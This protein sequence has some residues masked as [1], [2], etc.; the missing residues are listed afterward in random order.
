MDRVIQELGQGFKLQ[1]QGNLHYQE[2]CILYVNRKVVTFTWCDESNDLD[3]KFNVD[4]HTANKLSLKRIQFDLTQPEMVETI[5]NV[6]EQGFQF[7][8]FEDCKRFMKS[9][10]FQISPETAKDL[11]MTLFPILDSCE[12]S[13]KLASARKI[14]DYLSSRDK[15]N[16][17]SSNSE[18]SAG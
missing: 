8:L 4:Q 5:K 11:G 14:Y 6:V 1:T 2:Y 18:E 13:T 3:Y 12:S 7:K 10:R 9:S 16:Q 15:K 17:D